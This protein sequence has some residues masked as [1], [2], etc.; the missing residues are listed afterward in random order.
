MAELKLLPRKEFEILLHGER[1]KGQ[2]TE[3]AWRRF[4]L[5]RKIGLENLHKELTEKPTPFDDCDMLLCFVEYSCLKAG[6]AFNY[7]QVNASD[8]I[9]QLGR[10]KAVELFNH[11]VYGEKKSEAENQQP[12]T[13]SS[14]H[15]SEP[16][17]V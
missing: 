9:E 12:S 2:A 10:D 11:A 5:Q 17:A 1:I 16:V 8:W 15:F 14:V 7:T 6:K 4:C 3:W 13:T